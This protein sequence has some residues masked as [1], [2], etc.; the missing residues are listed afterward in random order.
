MQIPY[1]VV[2]RVVAVSLVLAF[3]GCKIELNTGL[4]EQQANEMMAKLLAHD[5]AVS[6]EPG[7]EGI[8]LLVDKSQFGNAVDTLQSYGLPRKTYSTVGEVF[9]A[10][11]LIASPLQEWA[12]LNFAK[13][14]ELSNSISTISG[15]VE[16]DVHIAEARRENPF[17]DPEPPRASV[18]VR[19][20]EDMITEDIIPKIKELVSYAIPEIT[21]TSVG[22]VITPVPTV[23]R[24]QSLT[25]VGPFL[26]HPDMA[27]EVQAIIAVA[28]IG[29]I[30]TVALG[31]VVLLQRRKLR[32]A[33]G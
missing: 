19:M 18:L 4:D 3:S 14:Q 10:D 1:P 31:G 28:V 32:S 33:A 20:N 2:I 9:D 6:K 29:A 27:G 25:A 30:S 11:G 22:V 12:R 7:K 15:V 26:V 24:T 8:T 5:I 21:Y 23:E 13:S 17:E 16:A